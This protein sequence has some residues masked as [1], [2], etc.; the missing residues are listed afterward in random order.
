M[1]RKLTKK[2]RSAAAKKG[3][4][5][6]RKRE[7]ELERLYDEWEEIEEEYEE[8][9]LKEVISETPIIQTEGPHGREA[10]TKDWD[11][12]AD[13]ER[14]SEVAK[15]EG[16]EKVSFAFR[17]RFIPDV[18]EPD[19]YTERWVSIPFSSN[20]RQQVINAN[21]YMDNF[22][23]GRLN[24]GLVVPIEATVVIA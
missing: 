21:D 23:S 15:A 19:Q 5:T 10:Y 12:I 18:E 3:W 13:F 6:R 24:Y 8:E 1:A 22:L 14:L 20:M 7:R 4:R 2:Q 16:A 11:G 9:E 17:L